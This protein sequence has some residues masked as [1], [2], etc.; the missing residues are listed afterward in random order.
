MAENDAET[1]AARLR[2]V[3]RQYGIRTQRE[4]ADLSGID[5]TYLNRIINGRIDQP[6]F[7]TVRRLADALGVPISLLAPQFASDAP[8]A[9][10]PV[11][12]VFADAFSELDLLTDDEVV[13]YVESKPGA[14]FRR[15]MAI[16]KERR[17][18][19]S[20]V[21]LCRAIMRAWTSNAQLAIDASLVN[22][23]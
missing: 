20:Y 10:E 8:P 1:F 14:Y 17:T 9:R 15:Q 18:R 11:P 22:E 4:L 5:V 19:A 12:A 13:A 2:R 6:T 16:Q 21:S 7:E 3:M 23:H